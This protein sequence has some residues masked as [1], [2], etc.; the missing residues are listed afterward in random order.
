MHEML[1]QG[2]KGRLFV[3]SRKTPLYFQREDM[4]NCSVTVE[5]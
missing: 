1:P 3:L 4:F 2:L 5:H